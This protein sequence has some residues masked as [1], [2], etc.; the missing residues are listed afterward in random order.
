MATELEKRRF[1][2]REI[3][4]LMGACLYIRRGGRAGRG[5]AD[6]EREFSG[7]QSSGRAADRHGAGDGCYRILQRERRMKNDPVLSS[8]ISSLDEWCKWFELEGDGRNLR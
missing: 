5:I 6:R 2:V 1:R 8:L 7:G 3:L 4:A